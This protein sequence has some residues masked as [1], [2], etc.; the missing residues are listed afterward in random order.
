MIKQVKYFLP[1]VLL[2]LSCPVMAQEKAAGCAETGKQ[3]CFEQ[4]DIYELPVPPAKEEMP[5]Q[6]EENGATDGPQKTQKSYINA[7]EKPVMTAGEGYYEVNIENG[8][9][10]AFE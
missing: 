7:E 9:F 3:L 5:E 1:F 4:L 6:A 8:G 10:Y 2:G